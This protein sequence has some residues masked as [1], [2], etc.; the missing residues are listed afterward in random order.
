MKAI[1]SKHKGPTKTPAS[2]IAA[3]KLSIPVPILPLN[4]WINVAKLLEIKL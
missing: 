2:F 1:K 4:K 3:G